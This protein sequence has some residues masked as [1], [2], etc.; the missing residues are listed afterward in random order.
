MTDA[1]DMQQV[2]TD[3]V[4]APDQVVDH[5]ARME[6]TNAGWHVRCQHFLGSKVTLP[7]AAA[8]DYRLLHRCLIRPLHCTP[9]GSCPDGPEWRRCL[10][11]AAIRDTRP[12]DEVLVALCKWV[13]QTANHYMLE[14]AI[15]QMWS[16]EV[17]G[18]LYGRPGELE[19][20]VVVVLLDCLR[21]LFHLPADSEKARNAID[22]A[23]GLVELYAIDIDDPANEV[24]T[25]RFIHH[26]MGQVLLEWVG[27][28]GDMH[29]ML[30]ECLPVAYA[31]WYGSKH[32]QHQHVTALLET[33]TRASHPNVTWDGLY[34]R[35]EA[36]K[37]R[38]SM[39]IGR[40]CYTDWIL[41]YRACVRWWSLEDRRAY[42][43]YM[44]AMM[45]DRPMTDT[46]RSHVN[47]MVGDIE[48]D[49]TKSM[50]A[51]REDSSSRVIVL[52]Y[53]LEADNY[54]L[55]LSVQPRGEEDV[56]AILHSGNGYYLLTI[57]ALNG[58]DW[59]TPLYR[60]VSRGLG[61]IG[62]T[63]LFCRLLDPTPYRGD[64]LHTTPVIPLPPVPSV[65]DAIL[66]H[67]VTDLKKRHVSY[68]IYHRND[69]SYHSEL[70]Y[71]PILMWRATIAAAKA[72]NERAVDRL[73]PLSRPG[74]EDGEATV[75][76]REA[77]YYMSPALR[78]RLLD[79]Y[80]RHVHHSQAIRVPRELYDDVGR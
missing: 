5:I 45:Q 71:P 57:A 59:F 23:M 28:Y 67:L 32:Y 75:P 63:R 16:R 51:N 22:Y 44:L 25:L 3:P 80:D 36:V 30:R 55:F 24:A 78:E 41:T 26:I 46:A 68:S 48:K 17:V 70:I 4:Q 40:L 69:G 74:S 29:D 58:I 61:W 35:L 56:R 2:S 60:G 52:R 73:L 14:S 64:V 77:V 65:S 9:L 53:A 50:V 6:V 43:E 10:V 7:Y 47:A 54:S 62:T 79:H 18:A 37:E 49:Y 20:R 13:N 27:D 42:H 1:H 39:V 11:V 76:L 72:G 31:T 8:F 21:C 38:H 12:P 34:E 66:D 33:G 19:G 15:I